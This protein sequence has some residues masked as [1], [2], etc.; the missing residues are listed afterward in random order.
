[1]AAVPAETA[2]HH[3][4]QRAA[5]VVLLLLAAQILV[6]TVSG[7]LL[8]FRYR[9]TPDDRSEQLF[10]EVAR[11]PDLLQDIHAMTS[12]AA[13]LTALVGALLLV[14]S[15]AD[16]RR[17]VVGLLGLGTV[18][19]AVAASFTGH[20]LPWDQVALRAVTVGGY[21]GGYGFLRHD[22]VL[23]VLIDGV[24]ISPVTLQRWLA[25][26][27]LVVSPVLV[28]LVV[29]AWRRSGRATPRPPV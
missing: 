27:V 1:M 24:E 29:A 20:L 28:G 17:L 5:R 26:H 14:L 4:V 13:V 3:R 8:Y 21:M 19:A 10:G 2:T 12:S 6:L 11:T 7:V 15:R 25:V 23:F 16:T 22:D 18:G 9:P